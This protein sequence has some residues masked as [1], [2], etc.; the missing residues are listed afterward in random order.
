M[1]KYEALKA[2]AKIEAVEMAK[3][4]DYYFDVVRSLASVT[5]KTGQWL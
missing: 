3:G 1:L 4:F 2:V 5:G